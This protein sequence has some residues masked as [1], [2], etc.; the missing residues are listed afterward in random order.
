MGKKEKLER[1]I[2]FLK[3]K[4]RGYFM[5]MLAFLTGEAGLIYS[6]VSGDKPLYI[7]FL[8]VVALFGI[9]GV[10]YKLFSL[11]QDIYNRLD[12]LERI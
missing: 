5:V 3:E 9:A 10:G 8:A 12:E 11:D 6:V 7:L 1:E 4:Y 2:D